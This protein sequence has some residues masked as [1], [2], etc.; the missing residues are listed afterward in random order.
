MFFFEVKCFNS[1][2]IFHT[3]VPYFC[4]CTHFAFD[5]AAPV[6]CAAA[7]LADCVR[8]G[9][10]TSAT[11][12]EVT[13]VDADGRRVTL[14]L[15][16][17]GKANRVVGLAEVG[18]LLEIYQISLVWLLMIGIDGFQFRLL[19]VSTAAVVVI[20]KWGTTICYCFVRYFILNN[21]YPAY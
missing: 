1:R 10:V 3:R 17:S 2:K 20:C 8:L 9:L 12:K 6:K 4:P 7:P 16:S 18:R 19:F 13:A 5:L 11:A 21:S 15:G 14:A